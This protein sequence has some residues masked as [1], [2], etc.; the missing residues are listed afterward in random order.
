MKTRVVEGLTH[1]PFCGHEDLEVVN[2]YRQGSGNVPRHYIRCE[3]CGARGPDS[4]SEKLAI[5]SWQERA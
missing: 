5:E 3:V 2:T 1:C 4:G